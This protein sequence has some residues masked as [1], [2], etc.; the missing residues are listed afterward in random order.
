[1]EWR[2]IK[3]V[4]LDMDGVLY[5]G[6]TP[7]PGAKDLIEFFQKVG[8]KY[9][10][11]TNNSARTPRQYQHHLRTMGIEV[12]EEH[13]LTS[14][15]VAAWYLKRLAPQ[16]GTV[17]V[18]GEEGLLQEIAAAGFT[19][20][21]E[22]P[23]FVVCGIDRGLTYEKLAIACRAI[24]RGAKFIGTNA[25]PIL[26]TEDGFIPG[27]GAILAAIT[28]ATGVEPLVL[29]KPEAPLVEMALERLGTAPEATA[30]IGDQLGTDILGGKRLGLVTILVLSGVSRPE[31]IVELGITP[32]LVVTGLP[33]LLE[34][35]KRGIS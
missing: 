4:I 6:S 20:T 30:I 31:Q 1:M 15:R 16:G 13:I 12:P 25:D 3:G 24:A 14:G 8:M 28:R 22:D 7:L 19:L 29:G 17:F 34:L 9:V 32:E 33:E 26:P 2:R 27:S 5:R 10:L 18:I 23:Q 35:W 11:A 21:T